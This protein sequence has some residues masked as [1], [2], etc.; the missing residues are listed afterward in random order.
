MRILQNPNRSSD[1]EEKKN[2]KEFFKF[3]PNPYL[4]C[5]IRD[6]YFRTGTVPGGKRG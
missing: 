1:R 6:I 2:S 4:S 5:Q 3:R